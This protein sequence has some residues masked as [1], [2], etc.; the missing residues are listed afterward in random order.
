MFTATVARYDNIQNFTG[1]TEIG[2]SKE[3]KSLSAVVQHGVNGL[4]KERDGK[5]FVVILGPNGM[6][7]HRTI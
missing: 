4:V 6:C 5:N 2:R 7:Q 1:R 3:Y